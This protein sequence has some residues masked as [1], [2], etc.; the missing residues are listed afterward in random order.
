MY[1]KPA[2][3]FDHFAAALTR[4]S[5]PDLKYLAY[6]LMGE[7]EAQQSRWSA[8]CVYYNKALQANP[9]GRS[10]IDAWAGVLDKE[11]MSSEAAD[12]RGRVTDPAAAD[13]WIAFSKGDLVSVPSLIE[14]LRRAVR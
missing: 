7:S 8:A 11:G 9:N 4:T 14:Q 5:D 1:A 13:P 6:F 10:V 2:N 12:M 3:A